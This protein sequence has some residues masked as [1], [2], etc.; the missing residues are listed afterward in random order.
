MR[1]PCWEFRDCHGSRFK[2]RTNHRCSSKRRPLFLTSERGSCT[3]HG[4]KTMVSRIGHVVFPPKGQCLKIVVVSMKM[5]IV[6]ILK[7]GAMAIP[8]FS[9]NGYYF[10]TNLFTHMRH[11]ESLFPHKVRG[12]IVHGALLLMGILRKW[13]HV[14]TN[15]FTHIRYTESLFPH[16]VRG[17]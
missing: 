14:L 12:M 3:I 9:A 15:L 10:L 8:H 6:S 1:S 16:K 5:I 7:S 11:I 4:G 2:D 13:R 17:I